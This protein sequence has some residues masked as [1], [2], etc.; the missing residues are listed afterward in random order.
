[1][2]FRQYILAAVLVIAPVLTPVASAHGQDGAPHQIADLGKFKLES[3][4]LIENLRM[5]Y[6]THGTLNE[7][8]S[9]AILFMHGFGANHHADHLIGAGKAFDTNKYFV[10][11]SDTFGNT[12]TGF[13]HSTSPTNSGMKMDFPAYN[14]R[15]MVNAE[16]KLMTEGLGIDHLVA[17]SG[18]SMGGGKTIQFAVSYP[19]FM[20]SAIPIVGSALWSSEGFLTFTHLPMIIENCAGWDGGAYDENPKDCATA[21]LMTIVPSFY[22]REWWNENITTPEAFKQWWTAW[23]GPYLGVQDARDLYLISAVLG[24]TT[25]ADTPGFDGDLSAALGAIK[26]KTLFISNPYDQFIP[27]TY[28]DMQNEM[29]PDSRILSIDRN[30][31]HFVCCGED[32]VAQQAMTQAIKK[33][34]SEVT[35]AAQ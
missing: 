24:S 16:Y 23:Y 1:M 25:V 15:D 18:I 21:A 27:P 20:D 32:P 10:I 6:V 9:N 5:S 14:L 12:Q 4:A 13:E 33:F 22:T 34:L 28:I 2:V 30:V 31:G 3:G 17:V 8:K 26:A 7:E 19:D 11:A 35:V 29:I